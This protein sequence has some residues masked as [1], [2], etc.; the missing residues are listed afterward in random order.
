MSLQVSTSQ[1]EPQK[2]KAKYELLRVD[3]GLSGRIM[4]MQDRAQA[5]MTLATSVQGLNSPKDNLSNSC[6]QPSKR[7][8][9][10]QI[11]WPTQLSR[12]AKKQI[13][14]TKSSQNNSKPCHLSAST[15]HVKIELTYWARFYMKSFVKLNMLGPIKA[16]GHISRKRRKYYI[17][18]N[19]FTIDL[20]IGKVFWRTLCDP[21][22]GFSV[23]ASA[24]K[25]LSAQVT[26]QPSWPIPTHL[27]QQ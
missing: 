12:S 20:S 13:P 17:I 22:H 19:T 23:I 10:N 26:P 5:S 14:R 15:P 27:L 3:A 11:C 9:W 6:W 8:W 4:M 24:F 7:A 2:Y 16:Y 1:V 21:S 18:L 25:F